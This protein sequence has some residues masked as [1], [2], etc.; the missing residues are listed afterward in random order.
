[1]YRTEAEKV[2]QART[3]WWNESLDGGR[4]AVGS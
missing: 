3:L 1:V 2:G 4:S